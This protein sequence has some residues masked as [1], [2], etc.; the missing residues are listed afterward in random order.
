[1]DR[2]IL[3]WI[4][5]HGTPA[6]DTLFRVSNE[7][8]TL[9][10]C[11]A[12]IVAAFV[13]HLALHERREAT[14]WVVV[15]LATLL[16]TE[17]IK[18]AVGRQRPALWPHLVTVS[19][20]A[21]PSGHAMAFLRSIDVRRVLRED[22]LRALR[23]LMELLDAAG[24]PYG[25]HVEIGRWE[26]TIARFAQ[27]RCCKSIVMGGNASAPLANLLLRLDAW[28]IRTRLRRLGFACRIV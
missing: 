23:P 10:F 1:M 21:F 3:I 13:W 25:H 6:L 8:G 28:R 18:L 27:E 17:T 15:G 11:A 16:L 4:H 7:L 9:P 14:A 20:F 22:G 12:L 19:G 26:E 5:Q 24:V 2:A